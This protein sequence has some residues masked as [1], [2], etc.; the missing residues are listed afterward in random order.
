MHVNTEC[1][2]AVP[3]Q[4]AHPGYATVSPYHSVGSYF[5]QS[6]LGWF[7]GQ[8]QH[9]GRTSCILGGGGGMVNVH[10]VIHMEC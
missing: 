4:L 5:F 2:H 6:L 7:V 9:V 3:T 8:D 10:T 1:A